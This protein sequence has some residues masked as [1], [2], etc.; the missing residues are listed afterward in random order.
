MHTMQRMIKQL[1]VNH[2]YSA[3]SHNR[4]VVRECCKVDDANQWE[5]TGNIR[6]L[7]TLKPLNRS[8]QYV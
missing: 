3:I 4:T 2:E 6:P 1:T 7:A 5:K 8:S